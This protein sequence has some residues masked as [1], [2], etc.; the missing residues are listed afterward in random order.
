MD[1]ET[2][3]LDL[4]LLVK[5]FCEERDWKQF[6]NAKELAIGMVTEAGELLQHFRFKTEHQINE[7]FKDNEK[8]EKLTEEISDVL[9]F[10]LR[11]AQLYD[12]DL[13]TE[14]KMKIQKNEG[15]YPINKVKG[16]NKKYSEY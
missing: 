8:R 1:K 12:V 6:H 5:K 7:M 2:T 3:I 15:K 13:T 10:T 16:C 14:L 9:Y 4:K 11:L